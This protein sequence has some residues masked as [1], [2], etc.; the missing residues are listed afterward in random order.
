LLLPAGLVGIVSTIL[1]VSLVIIVN[2]SD[3]K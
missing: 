3:N 1:V 2:R